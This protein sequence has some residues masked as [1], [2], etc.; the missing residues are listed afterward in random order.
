[1]RGVCRRGQAPVT[2]ASW[3]RSPADHIARVA[4]PLPLQTMQ[5]GGV[6]PSNNSAFVQLVPLMVREQSWRLA[7]CGRFRVNGVRV[8]RVVTLQQTCVVIF[9]LCGSFLTTPKSAGSMAQRD[10]RLPIMGNLACTTP[11]PAL[12]A[13]VGCS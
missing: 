5:F 6:A 2:L 3:L 7:R 10:N 8:W 11:Q 13:V 12:R 4:M 9:F 1:L